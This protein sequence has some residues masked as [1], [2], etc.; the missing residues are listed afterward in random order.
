LVRKYRIA[1]LLHTADEFQGSRKK[2]KYGEG[3]EV[4]SMVPLVLRQYGI[5]PY[6][7]YGNTYPNVI[8]IPLGYMRTMF[9][10]ENKTISGLEAGF[11]SLAKKSIDRRYNWSFVGTIDGHKERATALSVFRQWDTNFFAVGMTPQAMRD[12]YN[13]SKFVLVGRGQV[14]LDCY[15]IYESILCGALPIIVGPKLERE[16]SFE[17][18]GDRP[19]W[20]FENSYDD[21]LTRCKNMTEDEI[22][23]MRVANYNWLQDRIN[24]IKRRIRL[25]LEIFP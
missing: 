16:R 4:Y 10:Y 5:Y 1:I 6:R 11:H 9:Q 13:N 8:Q 20:I 17:F 22:D 7:S 3:V 23:T 24:M 18:E 25:T 19:P 15:R 14:N 2:W 12:V 21:A